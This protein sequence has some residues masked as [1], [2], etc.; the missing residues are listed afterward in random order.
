MDIAFTPD[1]K[2][3]AIARQNEI[4]FYD[5]SSLKIQKT[6]VTNKPVIGLLM[7]PDG[8]LLLAMDDSKNVQRYQ[9][10][11]G[12]P[13]GD[14]ALVKNVPDFCP[15]GQKLSTYTWWWSR[16]FCLPEQA[17]SFPS[18]SYVRGLITMAINTDASLAAL[19][20]QGGFELVSLAKGRKGET[21]WDTS[22]WASVWGTAAA[23]SPDGKVVALGF[24]DG[25]V[26]LVNTNTGEKFEQYMIGGMVTGLNYNFDGSLLAAISTTSTKLI[27]L[28]SNQVSE[29]GGMSPGVVHD[30]VFSPDGQQL[31]TVNDVYQFMLWDIVDGS[32]VY[33]WQGK[34]CN[35]SDYR[36]QGLCFYTGRVAYSSNGQYLALGDNGSVQIIDPRTGKVLHKMDVGQVL[37]LAFSP[38]NKQIAVG[39]LDFMKGQ[40]KLADGIQLWDV[41]SGTLSQTL[42]GKSCFFSNVSY[43]C[44]TDL[45]F[46]PDG[47]IL[48]ASCEDGI[49]L[50]D[51][52]IGQQTQKWFDP[53]LR[54]PYRM[55]LSSDGAFLAAM[56]MEVIKLWKVNGHEIAPNAFGIIPCPCGN[57]ALD[58]S[59]Q[60]IAAGNYESESDQFVVKIWNTVDQKLLGSISGPTEYPPILVSFSPV[61]DVLAISANGSVNF[62]AVQP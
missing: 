26:Y 44:T 35:I 51:L 5:T 50:W 29:I 18:S 56:G 27:K 54:S 42:P 61:G 13:L 39:T 48:I 59:G 9:L 36:F 62:Y 41:A 10:P 32:L 19:G 33:Q 30:M 55:K 21:K 2:Y 37:S 57:V 12:E 1:G 8:D 40:Q 16:L 25:I 7:S 4:V 43:N 3:I 47:Q 14:P 52:T 15:Q 58:P 20:G 38:D 28:Q 31:L 45:S 49:T 23:F 24:A 60:L 6:I 46:T 22:K 34:P 11:S 53:K 17:A